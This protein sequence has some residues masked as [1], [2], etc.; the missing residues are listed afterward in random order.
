MNKSLCS[1]VPQKLRNAKISSWSNSPAGNFHLLPPLGEGN[2]GHLALARLGDI[3]RKV[4]TFL[5]PLPS[6]YMSTLLCSL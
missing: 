4:G 2:P 3:K 1:L 5:I 6:K